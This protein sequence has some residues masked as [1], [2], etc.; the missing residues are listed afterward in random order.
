[1][2]DGFNVTN[3]AF[4]ESLY[5]QFLDDP[6]SV[7]PR[8]QQYFAETEPERSVGTGPTHVPNSIFRGMAPSSMPQPPQRSAATV[9][10]DVSANPEHIRLIS[11]L[12]FFQGV[13]G[14]EIGFISSRTKACSVPAGEHLMR[15]GESGNGVYFVL[16]GTAQVERGGEWV[17]TLGPGEVIG[18]MSFSSNQTR[19][20]DVI[21]Q[22]DLPMLHLDPTSLDVILDRYAVFSR[23][24]FEITAKRLRTTSMVQQRV[25]Q[26]VRLYRV[27]G[28]VMADLDPL[29]GKP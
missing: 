22:T 28:H 14:D 3:L 2:A 27:R 10:G 11:K 5:Q 9:P 21:A 23:R 24:L 16:E 8:W 17:A 12:D 26:L 13:P 29:G 4:V 18:G 20:A 6:Q 1:M 7:A 25:G 19:A 15:K